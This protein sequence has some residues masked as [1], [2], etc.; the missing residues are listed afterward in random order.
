VELEIEKRIVGSSAGPR[1]SV[2]S[3]TKEE[4]SKAQPSEKKWRYACRLFGTNSLKEGA[5]WHVDSLL[6]NDREANNYTTTIDK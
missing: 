3:E 2:P 5:I 6:G 1:G 4:M